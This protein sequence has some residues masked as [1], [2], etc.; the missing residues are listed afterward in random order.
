MHHALAHLLGVGLAALIA[1]RNRLRRAVMLD[2]RGMVDRD[3]GGTAFEVAHR[4]APFAHQVAY[5]LV[6]LHQHAFR[7]VDE[8]ALQGFPVLLNLAASAGA[9][10]TRLSFSTRF[11]RVLSSDSAFARL[12]ISSTARPYSGPNRCM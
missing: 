1:Q 8:T 2:N 3:I 11:S 5:Q 6:R 12:P 7:V 4:I 9:N 10:G